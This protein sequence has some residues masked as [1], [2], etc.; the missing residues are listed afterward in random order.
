MTPD[1]DHLVAL[2]ACHELLQAARAQ[3]AEMI[4]Q[5]DQLQLDLRGSLARV[6]QAELAVRDAIA[7]APPEG[8][9]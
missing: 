1:C 8:D 9:Q 4:G 7:T 5:A 2:G 3:L 6:Q